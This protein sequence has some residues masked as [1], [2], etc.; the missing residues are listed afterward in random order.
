MPAQ[1]EPE[2]PLGI[3]LKK[4]YIHHIRAGRKTIEGRVNSGMFRNLREGRLVRFFYFHDQTDDV[5]CKVQWINRYSSFREMLEKE[6]YQ[7][8]VPEAY[9]LEHAVEIYNSIPNYTE[10][11]AKF[12]V[13]AIKLELQR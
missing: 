3:T 13:L 1:R 2:R 6:G 4:V 8:C 11:A 9:S 12:G 7:A 10:N 5:I